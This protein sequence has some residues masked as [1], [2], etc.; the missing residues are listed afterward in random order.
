M[1]PIADFILQHV[2]LPAVPRYLTSYV[3]GQTPLST[4]TAV[5]GTLAGYLALIFGIQALM[6]DRQPQK[7]NTL[8]QNHNVTLS[9]GSAV[10]LVLMLEEIAPIIY[11]NGFFYA[12]CNE[13][14]WTPVRSV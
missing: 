2:P 11:R 10:L 8:F 3:P 9:A 5:W 12:I 7:L 6:T 1:A 13:G 4:P 14:S